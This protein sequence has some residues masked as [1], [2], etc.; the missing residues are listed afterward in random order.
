MEE[1]I[2]VITNLSIIILKML[3]DYNSSVYVELNEF[4]LPLIKCI[5]GIRYLNIYINKDKMIYIDKIKN[6]GQF[7]FL[8]LKNKYKTLNVLIEFES[9]KVYLDFGMFD[10]L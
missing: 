3:S 8:D 2:K 10:K 9:S 5:D 6:I 4:N 1:Y 7:A